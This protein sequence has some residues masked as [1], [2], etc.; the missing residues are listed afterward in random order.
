MSVLEETSQAII[1]AVSSYQVQAGEQW[2]ELRRSMPGV[3][4]FAMDVDPRSFERDEAAGV[5]IGRAELLLKATSLLRPGQPRQDVSFTLPAKVVLTEEDGA[6]AVLSFDFYAGGAGEGAQPYIDPEEG[7]PKTIG[8]G[9]FEG[10]SK[11]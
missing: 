2:N 9:P 3:T 11:E 4:F 10:L 8:W 5:W 1:A 6:L 7:P